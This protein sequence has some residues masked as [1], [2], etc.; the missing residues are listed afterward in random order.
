MDTNSPKRNMPLW[1]TAPIILRDMIRRYWLPHFERGDTPGTVAFSIFSHEPSAL[2]L[3]PPE[4]RDEF[5][6]LVSCAKATLLDAVGFRLDTW[7]YCPI[8]DAALTAMTDDLLSR[9]CDYKSSGC[10]DV[11]TRFYY[12][13]LHSAWDTDPIIDVLGLE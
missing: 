6:S 13:V 11:R 5:S 8:D 12:A 1:G 10:G 4:D 7:L 2:L 9:I 3:V